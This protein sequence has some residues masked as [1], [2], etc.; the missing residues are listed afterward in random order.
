MYSLT[1][2]IHPSVR[3]SIRPPTLFLVSSIHSFVFHPLP[4]SLLPLLL[5]IHSNACRGAGAVPGIWLK[6]T[7]SVVEVLLSGGRPMCVNLRW[8]DWAVI[9]LPTQECAGVSEAKEQTQRIYEE[10]QLYPM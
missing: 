9:P 8:F 4:P 7:Q 1:F 6:K 10:G 2:A 5:Q 3:P